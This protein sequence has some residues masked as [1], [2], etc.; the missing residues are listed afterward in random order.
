MISL[1]SDFF[2]IIGISNLLVKKIKGK[3]SGRD[4]HLT[5]DFMLYGVLLMV[6]SST[7]HNDKL[8]IWGVLVFYITN[9][10][11]R[12]LREQKYLINRM[13][14]LEQ[15]GLSAATCMVLRFAGVS[16]FI[17]IPLFLI[18]SVPTVIMSFRNS[19]I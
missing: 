13:D 4:I 14:V 1:F 2:F 5:V 16:K 10:N 6:L 19:T 9:R 15:I 11:L 12:P 8:I 18:L 7:A 3:L 17:V